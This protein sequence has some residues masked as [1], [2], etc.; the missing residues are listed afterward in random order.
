MKLLQI[1]TQRPG[2][3]GSGICLRNLCSFAEKSNFGQ[4]VIIGIPNNEQVNLPGVK[5]EN[6][7]PVRFETEN[8]PYPVVGMSDEMPYKSTKYK[9]LD[10]DQLAGW[11]AEFRKVMLRVVKKAKPDIIISHHLWIL[12]SLVKEIFPDIPVLGFCH[13]T[14]LRQLET[15]RD[16]ARDVKDKIS[17]IDTA[18]ALNKFQKIDINQQFNI[19]LD[20]IFVVGNGYND[21]IFYPPTGKRSSRKIT[22]T[23]AGKI[24]KVKGVEHLVKVFKNINEEDLRLNLVGSGSGNEYEQLKNLSEHKDI[25]LWGAVTQE[26]LGNI[27][28]QS[29][30]F[31]L[32]SFYEGLA[33]VVVEAL[34]CDLRVILTD[35]PG[36]RDWLGE[37]LSSSEA[38]SYIPLPRLYDCD[39]PK[40]EDIP[41]FESHL[42]KA[43]QWQISQ[44]RYGKKNNVVKYIKD[45]TW[46]SIWKRILQ[47]INDL[48]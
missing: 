8:L 28:R 37:E 23:F 4:S 2:W 33:L 11:K 14:G 21:K 6:I 3:T 41:Q 26:K 38:I 5:Q 16:L 18:L 36:I 39:K 25:K 30:I 10:Q 1:L 17:T 29:D 31:V 15:S 9:E 24:S 22:I 27:F 46:D 7:F 43:I 32:P 35:I 44:V 42:Y 40:T 45:K 47:I 19:A 12:T 20:K 34:A 13:G 48:R